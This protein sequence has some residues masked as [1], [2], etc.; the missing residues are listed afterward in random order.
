VE[1]P[2]LVARLAAE[3]VTLEVC[4]GSNVALGV[5]ASWRDHPLARLRDAGV[6]V[7]LST[8]D[9]PFFGTTMTDEYA[10]AARAFGWDAATLRA[11]AR[12]SLDAAF[13][14]DATRARLAPRLT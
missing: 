10:G 3:G 7:S 11:V 1:D 13:C 9:P 2:A 8:D 6:R 12:D 5:F 14:D 4:P